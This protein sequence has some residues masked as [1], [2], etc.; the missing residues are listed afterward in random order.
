ML[1]LYCLVET[2]IAS[3]KI[4]DTSATYPPQFASQIDYIVV[5]ALAAIDNW[6]YKPSHIAVVNS[7]GIF[8][9]LQGVM[10]DVGACRAFAEKFVDDQ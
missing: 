1:A 4:P 10:K 6:R 2:V 5:L 9:Q 8:G 3:Q 7:Q